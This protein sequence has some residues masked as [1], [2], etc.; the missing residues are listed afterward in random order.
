MK[1][2]I[3]D[4]SHNSVAWSVRWPVIR[5]EVSLLLGLSVLA[6]FMLLSAHPAR[7]IWLGTVGG[8]TVIVGVAIAATT[9]IRE[10]GHLERLPDGGELRLTYVWLILGRRTAFALPFQE[11]A[12]FIY[13]AQ[14]FQRTER[15]IY[16]MARL[17]ASTHDD[18][19]LRLSTWGSPADVEPLGEILSKAARRPLEV[20]R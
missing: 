15:S 20:A 6:G 9:P 4:E 12:G 17:W 2:E 19:A 11:L 13:E 1:L 8:F 10:E 7:W 16:T 18:E 5:M 3:T 14:D